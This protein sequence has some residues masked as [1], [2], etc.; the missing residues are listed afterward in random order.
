MGSVCFSAVVWG[1][2]L[3]AFGVRLL[4]VGLILGFMGFWGF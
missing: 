1:F 4:V 3:V 2:G